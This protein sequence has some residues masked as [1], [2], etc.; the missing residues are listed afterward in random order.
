LQII[1]QVTR[2]GRLQ[3]AGFN[4]IGQTIDVETEDLQ[5]A[6][7]Q[8][9]AIHSGIRLSI[10]SPLSNGAAPDERSAAYAIPSK[11]PMPDLY[12]Y[13]DRIRFSAKLK[14]PQNFRNPGAFDYRA[15]LADRNIAALGSTKTEDVDRLPGFAVSRITFWRSRLHRGV[16]DKVHELWPPPEAALIDAMVIGEDAFIDRDTRIDF[17]RSGTHHVLV[18]SGMNVSILAFVVFWTLRRLRLGDVPATLL[19]ISFCVAYAFTT[20][21][22]ARSGAPR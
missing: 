5:T 7:G 2:D 8:S 14:L 9:E 3:P 18:V 4:E 6:A 13:G 17:Q 12:H 11:T 16:V 22:G 21:V 20:E 15:Y 19:T 1:A 10:Y